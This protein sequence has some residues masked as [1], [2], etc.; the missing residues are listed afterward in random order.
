MLKLGSEKSNNK[1]VEEFM[2]RVR[3]EAMTMNNE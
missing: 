2:Q 3:E 1:V